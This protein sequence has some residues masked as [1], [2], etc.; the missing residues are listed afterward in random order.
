MDKIYYGVVEDRVSDPLKLGRLKVRIVGVHAENKIDLPTKDLPY[1]LVMQP[2]TSAANSGIGHSPTGIIEGT[3]VMLVFRDPDMQQ[4]VVIGTLP[5]IPTTDS[6]AIKQT[7][8]GGMVTSTDGTV[9][10]DSSGTPI[11]SGTAVEATPTPVAEVRKPS[12]MTISTPG[13]EF[14]KGVEGLSSIVKGKNKIG[15]NSMPDS[16]MIYAYKD[17]EGIW[18]IGWGSTILSNKTRVNADTAITKGECGVLFLERIKADYDMSA[19]R[20]IKVPVTQSMYDACVSMIYNMGAAGF[21]KTNVYSSLNAGRYEEAAA[22]IP[23][24]RN[25]SGTLIPRRNKEKNLFLQDGIPKDDGTTTP[26]LLEKT[27]TETKATTDITKNP[28]VIKSEQSTKTT[29]NEPVQLNEPGFKDPNKKYPL[30]FNEPDTNRLS[31]HEKID[32]TIVSKKEAAR[33]TGVTTAT[34]STWDQPK[35]PYN[36]IYPF[37]TVYASESG[38]IQEY[39]DT[40]G[41]ERTHSYHK[42]G[43]YSEVDVNGTRVNRIV[44]DSF[45]ILERNG[46]VIIRGVCNIT[47]VGDANLRVENNATIEALGNCDLKVGGNIGIGAGGD[48]RMAAG[49][50]ISLDAATIDFNSGLGGGVKKAAGGASGVSSLTPLQV[51]NRNDVADT[52][53]ETPEDGDPSQFRQAQIEAGNVDPDEPAV[54]AEPIATAPPEP[55]KDVKID[56]ASCDLI[57]KETVFTSSYKL[58]DNF[59]LGQIVTGT[60]ATYGMPSGTNYGLSAQAIVCNLKQLVVNI[61]DPVK[62]KYPNTTWSNTW[63]SEAFNKTLKGA[64]STSD[65]LSGCAVDLILTGF[66]RKQHYEAAIELQKS[67]P[68]Y[69]QIILEY[70][71]KTAVWIHISYKTNGNKSDAF[72]MNNGSTVPQRGAK[73]F[74][75]LA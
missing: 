43:T 55:K 56:P 32:G 37:N 24:A 75:L 50:A 25:N 26:A 74:T 2:T 33:A 60:Q 11:T 14:I 52:M 57:F 28:A 45:T 9:W 29:T 5:G 4:P 64:S 59:T 68:A 20:L 18:T 58:T 38:H 1:A 15:S 67:L 23:G 61:I 12:A 34:G 22:F 7:D 63:R 36:A 71:G 62:R 6:T 65:H 8:T 31:R 16:T 40:P 35:I 72:T 70:K 21:S 44:G 19:R 42:A 54:V 41:S 30:V 39:D 17:S 46:N 3:W 48:I 73:G 49:G 47:I 69:N 10:K 27:S 66:T 53:Y 13:L 51:P